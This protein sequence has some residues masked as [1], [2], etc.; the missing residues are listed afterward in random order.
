MVASN[1]D[2]SKAAPD[3][4]EKELMPL[5]EFEQQFHQALVEA[6]YDSRE[7]IIDLVREVKQ[8][9]YVD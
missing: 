7:K 6:G 2:L 5:D 1:I 9:I 3:L 8:E 4:A